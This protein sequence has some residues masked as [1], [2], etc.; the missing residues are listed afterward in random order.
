M[1]IIT[2][3]R[4]SYSKGKEVA[5]KV[6]ERLGYRCIARE[7][8]LEASREYGISEVRLI[9]AIHDAPS[10]LDRF[11]YGKEKYIAFI[12]SSLLKH[13][14]K[15]NVIYHGLAGHFF[16][17]NI[18]HVLKVRIIVDVE[19]RIAVEMER[20]KISREA[21]LRMLRKDD[22]ERRK[23][24]QHLYGIDTSD[25]SLYDL[26]I[27]IRKFSADDAADIISHTARLDRFRTT[28]ESQK[29]LD[30]LVLAAEVKAALIDLRHDVE[31]RANDGMI[32]IGT[33]ISPLHDDQ[34]IADL[35]KTARSIAGVK[36]VEIKLFHRV[37]WS[38]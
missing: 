16:V 36:D 7:I 29:A 28:P 3:S 21:A 12:Q 1:A 11:S 5:E 26:V 13:L 15:D 34:L 27:R 17:K 32:Y 38:D 14:Q 23:W 20:E 6:A 37:D 35:E 4:G 33:K 24:G 2:I 10:I 30:D 19:D 22:D 8:L 18:S 25:P 31:V 9:R